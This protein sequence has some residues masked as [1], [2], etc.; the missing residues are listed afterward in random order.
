MFAQFLCIGLKRL[1]VAITPRNNAINHL[2]V[3]VI[4][5][6]LIRLIGG[7][8]NC[9]QLII[10][11]SQSL[12]ASCLKMVKLVTRFY[13]ITQYLFTLYNVQGEEDGLIDVH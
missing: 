10:E 2:P 13:Y 6:I 9:S 4:Y 11:G 12:L 7:D 8:F 5:S 1:I 3:R